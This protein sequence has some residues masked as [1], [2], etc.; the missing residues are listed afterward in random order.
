MF[1]GVR[2]NTRTLINLSNTGVK[3]IDIIK[4]Y[5]KVEIK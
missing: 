1:S 5:Q 2:S 4:I 3:N